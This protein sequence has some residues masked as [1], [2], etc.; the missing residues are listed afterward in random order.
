M[1]IA[2]LL[3]RILDPEV[4]PHKFSLEPGATRPSD[5]GIPKV[6]S[7]FDENALELALQ[8]REKSPGST[9]TAIS[10]GPPETVEILRKALAV[11]ADAA[12]LVQIETDPGPDAFGTAS[13]LAAALQKTGPFDLVLAGR[14]AGD[15]DQ[16]Q[17]GSLVAEMLGF[18]CVTFVTQASPSGN[19]LRL[20][21][22][23]E[24][25]YDVIDADLPLVLTVTNH[26][27]NVLRLPKVRDVMMANRKPVTTIA[28]SDLAAMST[29]I[30]PLEILA[31][32]KPPA[33]AA[34]EIVGGRDEQEIA[35]RLVQKL[36]ELK[37]L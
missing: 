30:P 19:G 6:I 15:W 26:P 27:G 35:A 9:V 24:N 28:A 32:E 17:V 14:Q 3:K 20:Q 34:A 25:G 37:V 18:P 10:M 33:V 36:Q 4:S 8:L 7:P 5:A 29:K 23:S 21:R 1:K 12:V 16:G 13:T 31:L 2:I 22:E 11:T